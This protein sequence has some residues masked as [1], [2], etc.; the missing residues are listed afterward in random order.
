VDW[1]VGGGFRF[2]LQNPNGKQTGMRG[3]YR[4]LEAPVRSVH[5]EAFDDFPGST[6]IVTADFTE[7]DG[8][9]TMTAVVLYPSKEI[10]DIVAQ[11]GMQKGATETYERLEELLAA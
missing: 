4:E 8:R 1:R 2:V 9:T 11:S 3:V 10:R 6:S 5:E 7:R